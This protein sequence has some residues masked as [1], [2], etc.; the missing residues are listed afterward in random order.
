MTSRQ[1]KYLKLIWHLEDRYDS[2]RIKHI[3]EQLQVRPPTVLS[4]L[5]QLQDSN[6]ITYNRFSGATLTIAGKEKAEQLIRKHRLIESFLMQVLK[7]EEPLLHEEAERLELVVSDRLIGKID[8]YLDYPRTD[9]HGSII[10]MASGID[11]EIALTDVETDIQ[12]KVIKVPMRGA[13]KE[14]C[15]HNGFMPGSTWKV[16]QIGPGGEAFLIQDNEKNFLAV[17]DHLAEKIRVSIV[18][19]A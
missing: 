8:E 3:A 6:F 18:D 15:H 7:L 17:S 11:Q 2:A 19:R 5:R 16:A 10:P 13:E 12:F 9:P 1:Q 4:M 14:F